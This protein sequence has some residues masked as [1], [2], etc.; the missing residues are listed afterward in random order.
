MQC[1]EGVGAYCAAYGENSA[2]GKPAA[3]RK[4]GMKNERRDIFIRRASG[5]D[6]RAH[7]YVLKRA[8]ADVAHIAMKIAPASYRGIVA[9][10]KAAVDGA[11]RGGGA[12]RQAQGR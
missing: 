10:L 7:H 6:L 12:Q 8:R 9:A 4:M 5:G 2:V 1:R 11:L 3:I